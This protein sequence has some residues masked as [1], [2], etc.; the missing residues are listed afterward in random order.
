MAKKKDEGEKRLPASFTVGAIALSFLVIGYQTA[1]FVYKSAVA[2]I[3][4]GRDSPDTVFVV[5]PVVAEGLISGSGDGISASGE[6]DGGE[7]Y[8]S[9]G[10]AVRKNARHSQSVQSYRLSTTPRSY[11]SFE[12]NPNTVSMEDLVRLGFSQRQAESIDHYRKAGGRFRRKSDFAKSYVV[13]DSVYQ[14][15]EPYIRIPCTDLNKADSAEFDALPGIGGWYASRMVAYR[16]DLGGYSFPEQLLD[17]RNFGQERYDGL[18]D[19]I[20]VSPP[21]PYPIWSLPE[22]SLSLH[23][24]IG[25]HSAHGIVLF[26]ENNPKEKWDVA[27]LDAAGILQPGMAAKLSRCILA[28]P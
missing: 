4:A 21:S 17:I 6:A 27:S 16:E 24:Y 18:A 28:S 3:E 25:K 1:I 7:S 23:P 14:R 22:D 10:Y 12:F 13:E 11:E 8:G 15:L 5:D 20:T 26:R 9:K 19:L 2:R